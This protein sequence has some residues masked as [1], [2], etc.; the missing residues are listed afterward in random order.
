MKAERKVIEAPE[1]PLDFKFRK[2]SLAWI[3]T[4]REN[5]KMLT[6]QGGPELALTGIKRAAAAWAEK[7]SKHIIRDFKLPDTMEGALQLL[8]IYNQI[9]TAAK[10][11]SYTEGKVGYFE[12]FDCTHWDLL[13][14][15]LGIRCD[16]SCENHEIPGVLKILGDFNVEFTQCRPRGADRCSFKITRK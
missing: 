8:D 9:F 12:I 10:I 15:P 4:L 5:I 2:I 14:G 1:P 13:C 11:D 16:E 7:L 3:L 6:E